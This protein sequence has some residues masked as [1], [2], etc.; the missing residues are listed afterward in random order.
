MNKSQNNGCLSAIMFV[1]LSILIAS[2]WY[3]AMSKVNKRFIYSD[4][5]RKKQSHERKQSLIS[6]ETT[7]KTVN[8]E[9]KI[10]KLEGI[11]YGIYLYSG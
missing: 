10:A 9:L 7:F 2:A 5:I 1:F 4:I 3:H 6:S 11:L 8:I